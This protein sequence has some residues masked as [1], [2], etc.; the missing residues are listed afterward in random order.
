MKISNLL[1]RCTIHCYSERNPS[2]NQRSVTTIFSEAPCG[3]VE[4]ILS[5]IL[6]C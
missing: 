5:A 6:V 2:R 4:C 1:D 3:F